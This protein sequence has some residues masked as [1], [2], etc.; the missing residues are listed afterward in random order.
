MFLF[1]TILLRGLKIAKYAPDDFG[2]Y[3]AIG[4]T[5]T[6]VVYALG[7]ALVTLGLAPTTGLPMPF[8][9]YGG[10]AIIL[11]SFAIGVL[12]NIS[13]QTDL[14]PRERTFADPI[15]HP[16]PAVGKIYQ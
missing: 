8:V 15:V 10:S 11:S 6:I 2:K 5:S 13:S 7:N 14:H 3:L 12:L 1:L 9:S 16:E 4:I